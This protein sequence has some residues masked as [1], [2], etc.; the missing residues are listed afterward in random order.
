MDILRWWWKV[1][2]YETSHDDVVCGQATRNVLIDAKAKALRG[3]VCCGDPSCSRNL[4]VMFVWSFCVVDGH[5]SHTNLVVNLGGAYRADS[6]QWSRHIIA[7][8]HSQFWTQVKSF[9]FGNRQSESLVNWME[10]SMKD[11]QLCNLNCIASFSWEFY[12]D[13]THH[14][15]CDAVV[16]IAIFVKAL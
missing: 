8:S 14:S 6:H 5:L 12:S 16:G 1:F 2:G 4:R 3:R 10:G 15:N 13:I 11:M 7:S 9:R